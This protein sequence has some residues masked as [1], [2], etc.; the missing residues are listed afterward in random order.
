[1]KRFAQLDELDILG[2]RSLLVLTMSGTGVFEQ[3]GRAMLQ[4]AAQPLADGRYGDGEE[5]RGRFDAKLFGAF[6]EA[7]AMVV[8]VLI[9]LTHQI[10]IASGSGHDAAILA[11]ARPLALLQPGSHV[12]P[13]FRTYAL[14]LH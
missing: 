7:H 14:Q 9:H 13:P 2:C 12:L 11:A 6:C 1:V 5:P 4:E 3:V 8:N 10:E